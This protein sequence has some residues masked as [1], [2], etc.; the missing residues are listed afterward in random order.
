MDLSL[1]GNWW[2]SGRQLGAREM[3]V[4]ELKVDEE[5][6]LSSS[7]RSF[8]LSADGLFLLLC[9]F[10]KKSIVSTLLACF[11]IISSRTRELAGQTCIKPLSAIPSFLSTR[12]SDFSL[13]LFFS[14]FSGSLKLAACSFN[15]VSFWHQPSSSL[16]FD[17]RIQNY[18]RH[19]STNTPC[20]VCVLCVDYRVRAKASQTTGQV[21][22]TWSL[23]GACVVKK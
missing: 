20:V 7:L 10:W 13:L 16:L 1:W 5:W 9:T 4:W 6:I 22:S 14:L 12:V 11:L 8:R 3:P 15:S 2:K 21:R 23:K 17:V 19:Y 18:P